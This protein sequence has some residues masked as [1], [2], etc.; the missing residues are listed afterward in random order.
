[1]CRHHCLGTSSLPCVCC[2]IRGL[3][4]SDDLTVRHTSQGMVGQAEAR[5]AAG[6]V[7]QMIKE[8]RISGRAV[9]LAGQPGTGKTAIAMAMATGTTS[10]A[11]RRWQCCARPTQWISPTWCVAQMSMSARRRFQMRAKHL[12]PR[13]SVSQQ[14]HLALVWL[15]RPHPQPTRADHTRPSSQ[16]VDLSPPTTRLPFSRARLATPVT[17]MQTGASRRGVRPDRRVP[18]VWC[19]SDRRRPPFVCA[20]WQRMRVHQSRD[21]LIYNIGT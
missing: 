17:A 13:R 18:C 9:L 20:S 19:T 4:L 1:L 16:T 2:S 15:S 8:G 5:R 21:F 7:L 11:H 6:I 14:K 3:G 10:R 12:I